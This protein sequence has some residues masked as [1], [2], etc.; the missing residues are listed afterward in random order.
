M[1][2]SIPRRARIVLVIFV[3]WL[4]AIHVALGRQS[5]DGGVTGATGDTSQEETDAKQPK[6]EAPSSRSISERLIQATRSPIGAS[7]GFEEVY[8]PDY[9]ATTSKRPFVGYTVLRPRMFGHKTRKRYDFQF[10]YTYT[11]RANNRQHQIRN[12]DHSVR[13]DFAR[14]LSR[15]AALQL[16]DSFRSTFNDETIL[17]NSGDPILYQP[18]FEQEPYIP[19]QRLTTNT[20]VAGVNYQAGK[21]LHLNL[22]GGHNFWRYT[23]AKVGQSQGFQIG[24]RSDYRMNKWIYLESSYTHYLNRVD[25]RF[26]PS[27]IHRLQIGGLKFKPS[28]RVELYLSSGADSTRFQGIQRYAAAFQGGI[29]ANSRDSLLS[30]VYSRGFSI[31][32]VAG[33]PL[34][35]HTVNTSFSQWLS[36]RININLNSSYVRGLSATKGS[37]LEYITGTAEVGLAVQS[38]VMFSTQ[39]S[40]LSQRGSNLPIL[41]RYVVSAGFQFFL[42][43]IGGGRRQIPALN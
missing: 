34:K 27:D 7:L 21:R 24:V 5:S 3:T 12:T 13:I 40:Y 36:R 25:P 20:L 41:S 30:I 38:H 10:D 17:P 19:R 11:Y 9:S 4:G 32:G 18:R 37:K 42:A 29:S 26:L 6:D 39:Y 22:F 14:R 1:V 15:H 2:H 35:S 31:A 28:R 16:S 33:M 23:P 8:V 43:P